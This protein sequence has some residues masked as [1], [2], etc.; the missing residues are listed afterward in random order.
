MP[1]TDGEDVVERVPLLVGNAVV[2]WLGVAVAVVEPVA[3]SLLLCVPLTVVEAEGGMETVALGVIEV[4]PD[5]VGVPDPVE[6]RVSVALAACVAVP[7]PLAACDGEAELVLLTT[8]E[9]VPVKL[10]V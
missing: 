4:E 9:T 10:L 6:L 2:D 5:G 7:D 8:V 3:V 1:V